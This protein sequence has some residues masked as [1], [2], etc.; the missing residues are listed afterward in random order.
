[1]RSANA[2]SHMHSNSTLS[3][4]RTR[5]APPPLGTRSYRENSP[6]DGGQLPV[7]I[8][9]LPVKARTRLPSLRQMKREPH[10]AD[11]PAMGVRDQTPRLQVGRQGSI[12]PG[13]SRDISE[14][15]HSGKRGRNSSV[16]PRG[17]APH[18]LL[19]ASRLIAL[20]A[21][22]GDAPNPRTCMLKLKPGFISAALFGASKRR[23][24][25]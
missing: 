8:M 10:R 25:R 18:G 11:R 19:I 21:G 5:R 24:P 3:G 9:P 14:L 7:P 22:P 20:A 17:R 16:S 15:N 4:V 23:R 12:K 1:V 13:G 2:N 6:R